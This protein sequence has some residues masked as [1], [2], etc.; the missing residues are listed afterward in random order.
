MIIALLVVVC[1]V[2]AALAGCVW[3]QYR[4]I[5]QLRQDLEALKRTAGQRGGD[6]PS[7]RVGAPEDG[8]IPDDVIENTLSGAYR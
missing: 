8:E 2:A 6:I 3:V 4:G 7:D 5:V 1:V